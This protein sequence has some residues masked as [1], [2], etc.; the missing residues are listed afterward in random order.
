MTIL[1]IHN[2][3][4]HPGGE[5]A[6]VRQERDLLAS[7]G[8]RIVE[9]SRQSAEI[10]LNGV[11]SRIRLGAEA[12]WSKRTYRELRS[13]ISRERPEVAYIHN[14][15]PLISC[16][17]YSACS[18]SGVP[19]VQTLH[20]YRLLCPA[21]TFLR[22]GKVCEDCLHSNLLHSIRHRCYQNSA[23]ASAALA[24]VLA[25]QRALGTWTKKIDCF[26]ARTE[27][28]RRKFIE[29]G[30]PADRIVVKPCFVH[31]DPGSRTGAGDTA[32]FIGRLAPEKGLRTLLSAWDHLVGGV[33]LKI[34]GDGPLRAELAA[35]I[36]SHGPA[37]IR[38]LGRLSDA[39]LFAELKRARFLVFPSE[40]YEGLPL[41]IVEAFACGVPVLASRIGSM[42][43]LV[44]D[45]RT[46]LLFN[47]GDPRDLAAKVEWAWYHTEQMEEMGR[48]ARM[49]FQ[50]KYT[51]ERNYQLLSEIAHR[52]MQKENFL[53][54]TS[55]SL[56]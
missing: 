12:L 13:L 50:L 3:Y 54:R 28:A 15:V 5:D 29:S 37:N 47:S 4:R 22:D 56:Q 30:L 48:N 33:P 7:A 26:I 27:F 2:Y 8:H 24:T 36:A 40:W 17:A 39:E 11:S 44:D 42:I 38:L 23:A 10:K 21:G 19:V 35:R 18:D 31:P 14:T 41:T 20:N 49:E 53:L 16:S 9:Y 52:A 1:F 51:A 43:E 46:G 25:A 32:L 6:G 45:G 55:A 34:I